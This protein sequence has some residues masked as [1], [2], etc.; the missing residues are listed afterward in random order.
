MQ[1]EFRR[2]MMGSTHNTIYMPD[3]QA[4]RFA[5][6]SLPEQRA[7]AAFLDGETAKIDALIAEQEKLIE[8]LAEKRQAVISH[9]VTKGLNPAAPMKPS[10]IDW[11]GDVPAHWAVQRLGNLLREAPC[12]GVLVPDFQLDG[13]PMLRIQDMTAAT[14]DRSNLTTIS[15][16]LSQ[17]Y[18]R[19]VVEAGDLVLSVVGT[20]GESLVIDEKLR[21]VNLSRAVAR[22]QLGTEMSPHFCRW[23]FLG[24]PFRRY[25]DLIC[26]GTAQRVL[27]MTDLRAFR[28][29]APPPHEQQ[30]IHSNLEDR[31]RAL[32]DLDLQATCAI[33]LLRERRSALISAAV[34]GQID[35]RNAVPETAA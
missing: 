18:R 22:L 15:T 17:Q 6:P 31:A 35:V 24:E 29:A 25:A 1:G 16:D 3:I 12:Y 30:S 14:V 23:I 11:L 34:T 26:V 21:G 13:V 8:L 9:A 32:D 27:N 7:I 2:L 10:G 33:T 28:V 5:L 20:I 19:T 4:F